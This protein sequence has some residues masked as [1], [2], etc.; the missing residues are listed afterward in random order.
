MDHIFITIIGDKGKITEIA[1]VRT[2]GD[3][4]EIKK[5]S[6]K[7]AYT[8]SNDEFTFQQMAKGFKENLIK[9][10]NKYIVVTH[11]VYV[12]RTLLANEKEDL[13]PGRTWV[14]IAQ[15]A[16]PLVFNRTIPNRTLELIAKHFGV[17]VE[18]SKGAA[19]TCTAL[20]KIYGRLMQRYSTAL[21]GEEAIREMGGETLEN[22]R[23]L[24]GF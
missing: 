10:D 5:R 21:S 11:D 7:N 13:F 8:A 6:V 23:R 22:I 20:L 12:T 18:L 16:W 17:T 1:G 19:E 24:V 9:E 14:D 2:N 3:I 4:G 15:L